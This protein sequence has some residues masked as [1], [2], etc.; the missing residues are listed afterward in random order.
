LRPQQ[1]ACIFEHHHETTRLFLKTPPSRPSATALSGAL[2]G[3]LAARRAA[4]PRRAS[5]MP[6]LARRPAQTDRERRLAEYT[7]SCEI[8]RGG[9]RVRDFPRLDTLVRRNAK[10][11]QSECFRASSGKA[12]RDSSSR[13]LPS[14]SL[15]MSLKAR[16]SVASPQSSR[17]RTRSRK[18]SPLRTCSAGSEQRSA[19]IGTLICR[20]ESAADQPAK[21]RT[22]RVSR[23]ISRK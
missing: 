6:D 2:H 13:P 17:S 20:G 11:T 14:I 10:S 4:S 18:R 22:N 15:V 19:E 21:N 8:M 12:R 7:A 1:I 3:R 5:T 23:Q 16:T 9:G